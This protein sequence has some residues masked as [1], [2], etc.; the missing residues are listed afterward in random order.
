MILEVSSKEK[1][2][3]FTVFD[4]FYSLIIDVMALSFGG[5][6]FDAYVR[7]PEL[8]DPFN[9]SLSHYHVVTLSAF[10]SKSFNTARLLSI[11]YLEN[12]LR[13]GKIQVSL[14][15]GI[16][17]VSIA[18][19]I[20]DVAMISY[21]GQPISTEDYELISRSFEVIAPSFPDIRSS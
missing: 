7:N 11:E 18:S 19:L 17:S 13:N 4:A 6:T 15:R 8:Y 12:E 14:G 5:V 20:P 2:S 1:D 3:C 10:N 16:P 9:S 21:K